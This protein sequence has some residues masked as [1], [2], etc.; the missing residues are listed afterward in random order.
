MHPLLLWDIPRNEV[1]FSTFEQDGTADANSQRS[2]EKKLTRWG[3][4]PS[5]IEW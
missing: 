2:K 1:I 5:C 3:K 4:W